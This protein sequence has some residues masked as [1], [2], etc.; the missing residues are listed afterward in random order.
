MAVEHARPGDRLCVTRLDRLGRSLRELLETVDSLKAQGIHLVSL[1]ERL[2][3]LRRRR[4]ARVPRLRCHRALRAATDLGADPRRHR[5]GAKRRPNTGA[6]TPR[7]GDGFRRAET[8]RRRPFARSG[9]ET[10]Q[11][12]QGNGLQN[13]RYDAR[14]GSAALNVIPHTN[15]PMTPVVHGARLARHSVPPW[16]LDGLVL[17]RGCVPVELTRRQ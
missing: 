11:H 13:R 2:E 7:P 8:H 16:R 10:A 1:E 17:Q 4:R 15:L 9:R 6:S 14:R 12:R 3:H 5:R